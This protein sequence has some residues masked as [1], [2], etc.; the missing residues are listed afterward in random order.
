MG[1]EGTVGDAQVVIIA[2]ASRTPKRNLEE[3]QGLLVTVLIEWMWNFF[4]LK[5]VLLPTGFLR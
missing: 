1:L 3:G 2:G 4:L 5:S